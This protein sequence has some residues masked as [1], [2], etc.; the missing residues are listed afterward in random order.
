MQRVPSEYQP[1]AAGIGLQRTT[2][3]RQTNTWKRLAISA[4]LSLPTLGILAALLALCLFGIKFSNTDGDYG[5]DP[6][7]NVWVTNANRPNLWSKDYGLAI[8][9]GF[10]SFKFSIAKSI[11]IIFDL[12][13]GRGGQVLAG[14]LLYYNFRGPVVAAM[15]RSPVPY[16]KLMKM[17]YHTA[18]TTSFLVY[19]K[20]VHWKQT[21]RSTWFTAFMLAI[22]TFYVL[23]LPT[24]FSAMSGYQ[25]IDEPLLRLDNNTFVAFPTLERCAYVIADGVRVG[26][27]NF[28]CVELDSDL[29]SGLSK[30]TSLNRNLSGMTIDLNQIL[31]N[32]SHTIT[33]LAGLLTLYT[34]RP[35]TK[36]VRFQCPEEQ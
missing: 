22:S 6:A 21:S 12:V 19:C 24:W 32:M 36:A 14:I 34:R 2:P 18:G 31:I 5:C 16:D 4:A 35:Q 23:T 9:L 20:D 15:H 8:T 11:D 29:H 17:E 25:A 10:G 27:D 13:V 33:H 30:C 3:L 1:L 26:R 28:T 7:G